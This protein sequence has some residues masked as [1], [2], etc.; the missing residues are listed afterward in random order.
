MRRCTWRVLLWV[1]V[2]WTAPAVASTTAFQCDTEVDGCGF[3]AAQIAGTAGWQ[4][5]AACYALTPGAEHST[6]TAFR[7]GNPATCDYSGGIGERQAGTFTSPAMDLSGASG[8]ITLSFAYLASVYVPILGTNEVSVFVSTDEFQTATAV[9]STQCDA[10]PGS[11][12]CLPLLNDSPGAPSWHPAR[13]DLSTLAG[14]TIHIRFVVDVRATDYPGFYVDD[15]TVAVNRRPLAAIAPLS[16]SCAPSQLDGAASSDPDGTITA[17]D[18]AQTGGALSRQDFAVSSGGFA[19]AGIAGTAIWQR[20]ATCQSQALGAGHSTPTA[21]RFGNPAT[22]DYSGS[23]GERQAGTLTSP[24]VDLS[25]ASGLI[26]LSFAYLASVYVPI[27]GTNEASV[28]VSTDEFQTATPVASTQCDA[29]PGSPSCLP[30]FNDS[31]ATASW[32]SVTIDLSTLAGQ[33]IRIRFLVDVR[34]TNYPGFYVDDVE[35]YTN[36][37]AS[38]AGT[39][40]P[41]LAFTPPCTSTS[42][43]FQLIVRDDGY[44]GNVGVLESRPV[45]RTVV[46]AP[47]STTSSTTTTS[48]TIITTGSTT[49]V[50]GTT[51][52]TT[53]VTSPVTTTT[54]L[55][56]DAVSP[57]T[58]WPVANGAVGQDYAQY[59]WGRQQTATRPA[60]HHTGLDITASLGTTVVAS[61][62]GVARVLLMTGDTS[63]K[64]PYRGDNHCMGNVVILDHGGLFTLYGHLDTVVVATGQR[65]PRGAAIGT[66]GKTGVGLR[67]EVCGSADGFVAHLHFEVKDRGVLGDETD[68]GADFGYNN[69]LP[70]LHGYH[71][72]IAYLHGPTPR[73]AQVR[74]NASGCG[75]SLRVGPGSLSGAAE[76]RTLRA[77]KA[78]CDTTGV[79]A[80]ATVG[81]VTTGEVLE[82]RAAAAGT[83]SPACDGWLQVVPVG[84]SHNTEVVAGSLYFKDASR[85][86]ST[87]PDAWICIGQHGQCATGAE[88]SC[89]LTPE[90]SETN[91]DILNVSDAHETTRKLISIVCQA[92]L[93]QLGLDG[94]TFC[95]AAGYTIVPAG[96]S[97]EAG[98]DPGPDA[99]PLTLVQVTKTTKRKLHKKKGTAI[100][101]VPLSKEGRLLLKERGMLVVVL[102][103]SIIDNASQVLTD[104]DGQPLTREETVTIKRRR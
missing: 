28:F 97:I 35:I 62:S 104:R 96:A 92:F 47:S 56:P 25:G 70:D 69:G 94:K 79:L 15:L 50:T 8:L 37:G 68:H 40:A 4:R 30:L 98:D 52:T 12:S 100:L 2:A 65:I 39:H 31:P 66:V 29:Y 7:F 86:G 45:Y 24:P 58:V 80:P 81:A 102:R 42:L 33:A 75:A 82:V 55:L 27:L 78:T 101:K 32:H 41:A 10:Y 64:D 93:A 74:V 71:D 77:T 99:I 72:P 26:T 61:G 22:C 67:P 9:A 20:S 16:T 90:S 48:S 57:P 13:I 17:Y 21:F 23:I 36:L 18:W 34:A 1:V 11:P 46:V 44:G 89:W 5:S 38:I 63:G 60:G 51:D 87:I 73:R 84:P 91:V 53:T 59:N 49:T 6:P 83:V 85:S 76:Y 3:V 95:Q 88:Q 43:T 103:A 19:A 14:R 54:T